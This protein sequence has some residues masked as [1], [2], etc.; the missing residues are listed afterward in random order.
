MITD[1]DLSIT[2]LRVITPPLNDLAYFFFSVSFSIIKMITEIKI[3]AITTATIDAVDA[4]IEIDPGIQLPII[5]G[6]VSTAPPA[7]PSMLS[8]IP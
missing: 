1:I 5:P 8:K 6:I 7:S 3:P 2:S 4:K